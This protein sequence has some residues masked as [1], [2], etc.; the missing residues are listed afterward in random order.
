MDSVSTRSRRGNLG[1]EGRNLRLPH[2][3]EARGT[4]SSKRCPHGC[5]SW[6][7]QALGSI[8]A[9]RI[10]LDSGA[11]QVMADVEFKIEGLDPDLKKLRALPEKFGN[12]GM[13]RALRKGANIVRDAARN[14]AKRIDDPETRERIWKN[15]SVQGGGRRREKQAGGPMM[16]VGVRGGARPLKKGT[17]T[18]LPGGNTTH[19]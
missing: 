9:A 11:L 6:R 8:D 3:H 10:A 2:R 1:R 16:R 14:N 19:W 15:I 17:E 18:G 4:D 5:L 7:P 12:R 13:R